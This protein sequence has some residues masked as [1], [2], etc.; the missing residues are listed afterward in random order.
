M[1]SQVTGALIRQPPAK[2]DGG[3][4]TKPKK[5]GTADLPEDP[6]TAFK[7]VVNAQRII[8]G[9]VDDPSTFFGPRALRL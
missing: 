6:K 7:T 1:V 2:D 8:D 9:V 4:G 3:D 5:G